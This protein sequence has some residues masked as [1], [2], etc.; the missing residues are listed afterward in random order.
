MANNQIILIGDNVNFAPYST[1]ILRFITVYTVP[2][3]L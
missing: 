3:N 1:H 2:D